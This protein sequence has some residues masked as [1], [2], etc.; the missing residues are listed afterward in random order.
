MMGRARSCMTAFYGTKF[1]TNVSLGCIAPKGSIII[2]RSTTS[3]A[4]NRIVFTPILVARLSNMQQR[5]ASLGEKLGDSAE[6]SPQE[7]TRLGKEYSELGRIV[8]LHVE[9][10]RLVKSI[11][12][13]KKLLDDAKRTAKDANNAAKDEDDEMTMLIEE[14][15]ILLTEQLSTTEKQIVTVLTPRDSADDRGVVVEV[16]AG[17]GGDEASLFASEIF[18]MYQRYA[19]F[20][21]WKWEELSLSRSEIGGFKEAQA[22]VTGDEVFK[23][24]KF[25]S[26]VHRVQRIPVNDTKIQTSA[27]NVIVLPEASEVDVEGLLR[28]NDLRIDVFRAGGAGGQ[29]VNRTESAVRI[30]HLPTGLVVS[31]QDERSQIQNRARAMKYLRA[32]VYALERSKLDAQRSALTRDANA[33]GDRSDKIRTYNFPQDRVTDHRVGVTVQG[34]ERVLLGESLLEG[35]VQDLMEQNERD[36]LQAFLTELMSKK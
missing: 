14:E 12:E 18:K 6:L 19:A 1:A 22:S 31:M 20:K 30:T 3:S 2:S 36:R 13:L 27:A 7:L 11:D 33:S 29:S 28:P 25:E 32:K 10:Q 5:H 24:F 26:G 17:T 21:G 16:R 15:R 23:H 34:C 9:R 35:V 8:E 4:S